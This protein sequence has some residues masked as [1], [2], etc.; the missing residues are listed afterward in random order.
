MAALRAAQALQQARST[1]QQ[2][3]KQYRKVVSVLEVGLIVGGWV[4]QGRL[5]KCL[6]MMTRGLVSGCGCLWDAHQH[7]WC[8]A[9][10]ARLL[11][12]CVCVC[13]MGW[14]GNARGSGQHVLPAKSRR[15]VQPT[16]HKHPHIQE[17]KRTARH[18]QPCRSY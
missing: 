2:A 10:S 6:V 17:G 7:L 14:P 15:M 5:S 16:I 1:L 3:R 8:T 4:Y 18:Q 9:N 11:E 12:V 13:V